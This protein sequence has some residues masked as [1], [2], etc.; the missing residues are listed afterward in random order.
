[1]QEKVTENTARERLERRG[2][3]MKTRGFWQTSEQQETPEEH[4]LCFQSH[5]ISLVCLAS[6]YIRINKSEQCVLSS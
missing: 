6:K 1:M 5:V 4:H 3:Q 2:S